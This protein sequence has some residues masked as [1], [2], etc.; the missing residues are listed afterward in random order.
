MDRA[1][2]PFFRQGLSADVRLVLFALA[3]IAL[4]VVDARYRALEVV[5]TAVGTVLYPVQ[6]ALLAPR[7]AASVMTDYVGGVGK[8]R[9]DNER[10]VRLE[11]ANARS[12]Q[13][14]EHLAAENAQLRK[15]LGMR[16]RNSFQI[17]RAHV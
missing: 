12:L 16:E 17:G 5:R 11:A 1:P 4:L 8:L 15:L 10:L 6:R 7:D 14:G 9:D 2:P 3:A 13:Q